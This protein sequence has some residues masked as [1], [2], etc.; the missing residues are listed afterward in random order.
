MYI[1]KYLYIIPLVAMHAYVGKLDRGCRPNSIN[2]IILAEDPDLSYPHT[3]GA[4]EI[5][6]FIAYIS[7]AFFFKFYS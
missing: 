6:E 7:W 1:Y 5:I 2:F 4:R 3:N